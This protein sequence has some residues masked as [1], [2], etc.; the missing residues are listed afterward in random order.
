MTTQNKD[1]KQIVVGR[2]SISTANGLTRI[3]SIVTYN[4]E[5][6]PIWA[7]VDDKYGKYLCVERSDAYVVG[8]LNFAMRNKCDIV[9]KAPISQRLKYQ[10]E[11]FLI[12]SLV[13]HDNSLY[14]TQIVAD[15]D[16]SELPCAGAVG[17]GCSC[18][19]D[20]FHVI[21][22]YGKEK[23][24]GIQLT[25]LM[26]LKIGGIAYD[27]TGW[28][29][30]V[31]HAKTFCHEYGY[32]LI[33]FNTNFSLVF[34][35]DHLLT[36]GYANSFG[37]LTLQKLWKIYFYGSSGMDLSEFDLTDNSKR[38]DAHYD[39]LLFDSLST[40]RLKIYLDGLDVPRFDKLR[41]ILDFEPT[42]KYLDVCLENTGRNCGRCRKCKRT[43][44]MLDALGALDKSFV[45]FN[46]QKY[47]Q[48]RHRYLRWL[49]RQQVAQ[50][51]DPSVS[52]AY[53]IL[54]KEIGIRARFPVWMDA[55]RHLFGRRP[56][57]VT[58]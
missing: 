13:R 17:T 8:L 50:G 35:Q 11:T 16:D 4:G 52:Y 2:P 39:L 42:R 21:K 19:V 57:G 23:F 43:L 36:D 22:R 1:L 15:E 28:S 3:T 37:I 38:S 54:K 33:T 5:A 9:C 12:P 25:H 49:Y 18:G 40:E 29:L 44:V 20:S 51:G 31:A 7:E 26:L 27:E 32:E 53:E 6:L 47:R 30:K 56:D 10:L 24:Y 46:A 58:F 14:A 34:H 45:A 55:L 48:K 41:Y